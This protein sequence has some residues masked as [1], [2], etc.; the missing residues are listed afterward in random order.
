MPT[1]F[2]AVAARAL[3]DRAEAIRYATAAVELNARV[4][5][6]AW[7]RRAAALAADLGLAGDLASDTEPA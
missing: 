5:N 6:R 1:Y 7:G 2:L 4:G 3:G